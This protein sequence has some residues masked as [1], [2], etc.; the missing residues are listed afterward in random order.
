[1]QCLK[2][3]LYFNVTEGSVSSSNV[4]PR[5]YFDVNKNKTVNKNKMKT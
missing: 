5:T 1:M 4:F 2:N 3:G